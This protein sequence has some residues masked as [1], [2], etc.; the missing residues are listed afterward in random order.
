MKICFLI[1]PILLNLFVIMAP[2][3][4]KLMSQPAPREVGIAEAVQLLIE[5]IKVSN[6]PG[7]VAGAA[8]DVGIFLLLGAMR[9]FSRGIHELLK[10]ESI[11]IYRSLNGRELEK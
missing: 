9:N 5:G 6:T 10:G 3:M 7:V 4:I 8:S 1:T 2:A 11:Q